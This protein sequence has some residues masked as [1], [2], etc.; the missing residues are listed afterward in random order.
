MKKALVVIAIAILFILTGC[1]QAQK[2]IC[3]D[4]TPINF[5]QETLPITG[6]AITNVTEQDDTTEEQPPVIVPPESSTTPETP[7]VTPPATQTQEKTYTEGD[8]VQLTP[9]ITDPDGDTITITYS[10]PLDNNGTWQTKVGD[11]GTYN[12]TITADDGTNKVEKTITILINAKNKPPII[13]ILQDNII[14]REG[15]T[16]RIT[17]NATDPEGKPTT[18]TYTGWMTM[19][20]KTTDYKDAGIY[21]VTL[22]AN[23]GEMTTMKDITITVKDVNRPPTINTLQN[24][25]VTEEETIT[26][27]PTIQDPDGDNTTTTYETPFDNIGTWQTKKGDAGTYT[28]TIKTSDGVLEATASI[29]ITI[30]AKNQPPTITVSDV[31]VKE[32]ETIT[33]TPTITDPEEDKTT[34]TYSGWMTTNTKTT[35]YEDAGTYDV[36]ITADDGQ[37]N[38]TKKITVTVQN[39]N[40]PPTFTI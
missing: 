25:V 34:I 28:K 31:T 3:P 13:T 14:V 21:N 16:I 22:T 37:N 1:A 29:T 30:K 10:K 15:E 12:I 11:A 36:V 9:T 18:L 27:T 4:N 23:D 17:A 38:A 39:V 26:L 20:T 7:I 35:T 8:I 19:E 32:G 24:I 2:I 40:R 33:I 6:G 5:A